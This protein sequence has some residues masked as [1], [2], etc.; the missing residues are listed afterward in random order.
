MALKSFAFLTLQ[1]FERLSQPEKIAYLERA[2]A[3]LKKT[4]GA[5]GL[6]SKRLPHLLDVVRKT[7]LNR[8]NSAGVFVCLAS[9]YSAESV[10][11]NVSA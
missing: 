5:R 3:A 7:S 6:S 1:E 11:A 9:K 2:A 10:S 4:R 8:G